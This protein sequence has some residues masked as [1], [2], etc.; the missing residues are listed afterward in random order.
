MTN[1]FNKVACFTDIHFGKK[2]N[3][4]VFN[5]DC[6]RFIDWFI[7]NSQEF[8]AET[9]I[10]GGDWHQNRINLNVQ[11]FSSYSIEGVK[12]LVEN[13]EKVIF[14]VGNHDMYFKNNRR[15]VCMLKYA[16]MYPNV[17]IITEPTLINNVALIPWLIENEHEIISNMDCKYMFGHFEL[18]TFMMNQQIECPDEGDGINKNM[19]KKPEY[20]FSGH[21]HLR[22]QQSNIIYIGAPF[23][24]DFSDAW[25]DNKGCM[26]LEWGE[27]PLLL[28]WKGGPKYRTGV[29]SDLLNNEGN[30]VKSRNYL[31]IEQD[32]DITYEQKAQILEYYE[33]LVRE[34]QLIPKPRDDHQHT[35]IDLSTFKGVDE[36]VMAVIS[37]CETATLNKK[38]LIDIYNSI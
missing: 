9:C 2:N 27:E 36:T 21:F 16:E 1:F 23:S 29:L 20:V 7:K 11:T 19:L 6:L 15:D 31:K 34:F 13:F 30:F 26:L 18:P 3:S 14:I 32:I 28:N 4:N 8:G 35:T 24:Q 22:Q 12:K 5:Q 10:F 37:E 17:Q 33:P 25:D 38:M